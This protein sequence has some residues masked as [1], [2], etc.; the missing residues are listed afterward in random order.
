LTDDLTARLGADSRVTGVNVSQRRGIRVGEPTAPRE[1]D[2][3]AT[4]VETASSYF[5]VMDV[6]IL[7]G[8]NLSAADTDAAV[9]SAALAELIAPGGSPLGH[10]LLVEDGARARRVLVVGVAADFAARPQVARPDPVVYAPLP[11][12]LGGRF[13]V[14]VRSTDP[15]HIETDVRAVLR[16][17]NPQVAW[18]A[19]R[20]GDAAFLDEAAEMRS[21]VPVIA[22]C[23]VMALLL[24]STGLYAVISYVVTLR[25]REIGVRLAIGASPRD[26]VGLVLRQAARW[27]LRGALAGRAL[28]VAS[29]V[30]RGASFVAPVNALD[31]LAFMP[32][33]TL[34]VV[35]ALAAAVI[36]A[37]RAAR[38]NP[39]TTLREE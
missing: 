20:R 15:G 9:V 27:V 22:G 26:V 10:T 24:A 33:L 21:A 18:T 14:R 4:L 13:T 11:A 19:L 25:R 32:P 38:V 17:L 31:P 6:A 34:L 37:R 1:H 36:P 3:A 8:R 12:T 2:L 5:S 35:V 28:A 29:A 7:A 16:E 30:L 39:V 23:A